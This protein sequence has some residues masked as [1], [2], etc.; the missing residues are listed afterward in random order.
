MNEGGKLIHLV[1]EGLPE[2]GDGANDAP[3]NGGLSPLGKEIVRE[4]ERLGM[5]VDVSHASEAST[6][7]ILEVAKGPVVASHSNARARCDITRNLWDDQLKAI[8][9]TGGV[10]GVHFSSSMSS[11]AQLDKVLAT[12]TYDRYYET[13]SRLRA[14]Y[15]NPWEFMV[16]RNDPEEWRD[17]PGSGGQA[18]PA[19]APPTLEVLVD[20]IEY[21]VNLVGIDHVG[22]GADF[23]LGD[24]PEGLEHAG[25]MPNLPKALIARGYVGEDLRKILGDNWLRVCRQVLG[26]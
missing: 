15:P 18:P 25:K 26:G 6:W 19:V 17:V 2:V 13:V 10:I 14:K 9:Q 24:L 1:V 4:M 5:V 22:L 11:Q 16:H 21:L 23:D 20:Q 7:D 3:V 8:A 12:P